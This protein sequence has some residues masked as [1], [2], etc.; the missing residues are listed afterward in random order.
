MTVGGRRSASDIKEDSPVAKK[1]RDPSPEPVE[2]AIPAAFPHL[3]YIPIFGSVSGLYTWR[4]P[5]DR[6]PPLPIPGPEIPPPIPVPPFP[7]GPGL[8]PEP[9]PPFAAEADED[10]P[11]LTPLP[12]WW[13]R[14]ELRL[15]VDGRYPQRSASGALYSGLRTRVHWIARLR[16]LGHD[17]WA[18]RIWY[19]DGD[20]QALPHTWVEIHARRSPFPTQRRAT[21]TFSGAGLPSRTRT[22][23]YQSPYFHPVEFEFDVVDGTTAVTQ[24]ATHSHPNR[25]AALPAETLTLERVYE[26][27]GF[28]A[29]VVGGN[30]PLAGA[31]ANARWSDAEMHDAMQVYWSRFAD[32]PQ[33]AL[34]VLFASL[35]EMGTSLGGIMFDDIG[36]NHRQGT[37]IFNDSFIANAPPGD[38]AAAAWVQRMRFW[39]AGHEM[40]H[41]FN[42]AHSWQKALTAPGVPWIPLANEPEARSFMNYPYNVQGG[43]GAFFASF[44][45]R[46]SDSELLFLRHAPARFVQMGDANWFD[47]HGFEQAAVTPQQRFRLEVRANRE[48]AV[49]EFLEPIVLELKLTNASGAAQVI[50]AKTLENPDHLTVVI[51]HAQQPAR[52]WAPYAQ[53]CL[54]PQLL[55]LQPGRSLYEPLF[56][57]AGRNGFDLSEPGFYRIQVA[58]HLDG[59][60]VV[61]NGMLLQVSPP[62]SYEEE[63]LA[64]D[65]YT[66]EVGRVLAFDGSA[67]LG[68]ALDTLQLVR[69]QLRDRRVAVHAAVALAEALERDFKVL[70]LDGDRRR[71]RVRAA[72]SEREKLLDDVLR[73]NGEGA[74]ETLGN[75]DY[76]YYA[77]RHATRL[78]DEGRTEEAVQVAEVLQ[79]TLEQRRVLP[80]VL[81]EVQ[82]RIA[83][84]RK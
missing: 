68:G 53:R 75:I 31:G 1:S 58:L 71:I 79:R 2:E 44:D 37:A 50:D 23:T 77:E 39:T 60:D 78:H 57:S 35:H 12:A 6:P 67:V 16:A 38:A 14:E 33:W 29:S 15:D 62:G 56:V 11:D 21:V 81:A 13:L 65:F 22:Y 28:D 9:A 49:F 43:Q 76:R 61:S 10:L 4:I 73:T 80:E 52:Q 83:A 41:A 18:G 55:L 48:K 32:H 72:S 54:E 42:L 66:E 45:F 24:Y 20:V 46:F 5:I 34:W 19:K 69:D 74:A 40:G 17:R 8:G 47:H 64:Q 27:A 82:A 51:K 84:L 7:P 30:L 70:E 59:E 63:R 26:R 25:P 3:P 36:P